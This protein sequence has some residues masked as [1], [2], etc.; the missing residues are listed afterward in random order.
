MVVRMVGRVIVSVVA[1]MLV[2]L[3]RHTNAARS[4]TSNPDLRAD[5]I[6][7]IRTHSLFAPYVDS[8]LQNNFWDYGGDA[9]ID[10]NRYI[11]LTQDRKNESGWIL[12]RLPINVTD[13]EITSEFMLKGKSTTV[14]GDGFAM[15]LTS[16]RAKQ[17]PVF[18]S[19]N[20]WKGIGFMFDTYANTPHRGFFPRVS[21][22]SNDGT[23]VY[24][25]NNDG[26][27]Q[28]LAQCAM[29]LRQT[30]AET[31]LRF[32][33]VKDVYM[34]LAIQNKEWNQWNSCFKVPP[35][36]FSEP[37]F[38]GFT[39]STGDVTDSHSIVSVWTNKIVYNSRS[40]EDLERER[41]LAFADDKSKSWWSS[42]DEKKTPSNHGSDLLVH[43][44][45]RFFLSVLW[46]LKWVMVIAVIVVIGVIG[47]EMFKRKMQAAYKNRR[48][49]A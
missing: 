18:G 39:A 25:M 19:M 13:F 10:T 12:S 37:P 8:S 28:D 24:N 23:K 6:M 43:V 31:R 34:E 40:P 5:A 17:G 15:W 7:P 30:P 45:V 29:Q 4:S 16:D 47:Y 32:T 49:M 35:P 1:L 27:G 44:I 9:V 41:Q 36:P 46:L 48:M 20:Q 42:K 3:S 26:E 38:L 22:V 14:A 21:A 33:Y 2:A 11:M